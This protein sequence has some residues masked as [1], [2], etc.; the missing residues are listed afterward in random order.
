MR[1]EFSKRSQ[2][3]DP[4]EL[5]FIEIVKHTYIKMSTDIFYNKNWCIRKKS[6]I[7]FNKTSLFIYAMP[8]LSLPHCQLTVELDCVAYTTQS[9]NIDF[10]I[11]Y[12]TFFDYLERRL[13]L[14]SRK[15]DQHLE[16]ITRGCDSKVLPTYFKE[17]WN[18]Q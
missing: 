3:F 6:L 10:L 11:M 18:N 2:S 16:G 15:H 9:S 14:V 4:L 17:I 5:A 13:D 12:L 7:G 8:Q 1:Y